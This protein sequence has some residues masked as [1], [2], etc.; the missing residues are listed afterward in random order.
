MED[1]EQIATFPANPEARDKVKQ[2]DDDPSE[3]MWSVY[4]NQ[5]E[6]HNRYILSLDKTHPDVPST[7]L[8]FSRILVECWKADMNSILI[9]VS[10]LPERFLRCVL[11]C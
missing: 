1:G 2:R 7:V 11:T 6:K 8:P 10:P 5:V 3:N 9:F 4:M